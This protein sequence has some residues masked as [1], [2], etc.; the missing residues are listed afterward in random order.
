ML[1][2]FYNSVLIHPNTSDAYKD[3][4]E[5]ATWMGKPWPLHTDML[6]GH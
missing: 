3:H 4:T 1:K 6:K 2:H 5:L